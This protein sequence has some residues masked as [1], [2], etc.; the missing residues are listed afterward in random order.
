MV[1]STLTPRRLAK[2]LASDIVFGRL[3]PNARVIE[4]EVAKRFKVSRSPVRE[5]IRLLEQD[6]LVVKT[7]RRGTRV[8]PMSRKNL[9]EVYVCRSALEGV[10]AE[11]AARNRRPEIVRT[12]ETALDRLQ[13]TYEKS[14]VANYFE[15]NV[16]FTNAIHTAASNATL[17]RLLSG[18]DKQSSRYRYFAYRSFPQLME[19]SLEG[20]RRIVDAI[21]AGDEKEA[22]LVTEELIRKSWQSLA[23]YIP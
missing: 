9:D 2:T 5:A 4:E 21:R 23:T 13:K 11:L 18:I 19:A 14:D 3:H 16:A 12:L 17:Q 1:S 10:A 6:G 7:E 22:R 15:A 20:S 8:A